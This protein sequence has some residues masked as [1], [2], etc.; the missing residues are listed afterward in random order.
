MHEISSCDSG[1][2][3]I[4]TSFKVDTVS[5]LKG[6]TQIMADE[7]FQNAVQSYYEVFLRSERVMKIV[8]SGACSQHDFREVFRNNIEKRVS[9]VPSTSHHDVWIEGVPLDGTALTLRRV[10]AEEDRA[11][12]PRLRDGTDSVVGVTKRQR[13]LPE[14]FK[15]FKFAS[16]V[17]GY[18]RRE[19]HPTA[20]SPKVNK[21]RAN[22][23]GQMASR[24]T[25][26]RNN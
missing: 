26:Q 6:D 16:E 17:R 11:V 19:Y 20:Y 3:P 1:G 2:G 7:A 18:S 5:F 4:R 15:L 14:I 9:T 10:Q 8:Q 12:K 22:G 24:L 23:G 25:T 21:E 13:E